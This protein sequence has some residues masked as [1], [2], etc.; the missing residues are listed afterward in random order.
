MEGSRHH[1]YLFLRFQFWLLIPLLH[2]YS[3][4]IINLSL[5]SE[6]FNTSP[7]YCEFLVLPWRHRGWVLRPRRRCSS[8][9][10]LQ[11]ET[12]SSSWGHGSHISRCRGSVERAVLIDYQGYRHQSFEEGRGSHG[13][14]KIS[15]C[16]H[17][18]WDSHF[19]NGFWLSHFGPLR[20]FLI[21]LPPIL[22]RQP[23]PVSDQAV[24]RLAN[25]CS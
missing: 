14:A 23:L 9:S 1:Y 3:L 12:R 19:P 10:D 11:C 22:W 2:Q 25:T 15:M 21:V 8:Q 4:L 18:L 20:E 7:T 17:L 24:R 6:P 16:A 13:L 5:L